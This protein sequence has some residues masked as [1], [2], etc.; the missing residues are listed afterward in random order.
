MKK[1]SAKLLTDTEL[2]FIS[3]LWRLGEGTVSDV[4]EGLPPQRKPAY[5]SV[6]TILRILE[7][8]GMLMARKEGRGHIYIPKISKSEY[9]AR[10]LKHVVTKVFDGTPLALVKQLLGSVPM[11]PEEVSELKELLNKIEKKK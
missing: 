6:S 1:P 9:E 2:E 4:I 5:T 10:T 7:Q 8:K 11:K 3:V